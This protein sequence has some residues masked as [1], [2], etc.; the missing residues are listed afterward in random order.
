VPGFGQQTRNAMRDILIEIDAGHRRYAE[1]NK[2]RASM[3]FL[4]RR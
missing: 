1:F 2:S 4:C 3:N